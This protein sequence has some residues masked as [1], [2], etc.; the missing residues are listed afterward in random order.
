MLK[1]DL[2]NLAAVGLQGGSTP[3]GT[4]Q[5]WLDDVACTGTEDRLIECRNRG[6]GVHN[7]AHSEDAGVRCTG[8]NL[9]IVVVKFHTNILQALHA[10][11]E[12]SDCKEALPEGD[13]WR[14]ATTMP[15]AQCVTTSGAL[16]MLKW[17]VDSWDSVQ[18]VSS[19][20]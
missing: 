17:S 1:F 8:M 19:V 2:I 15:G 13:A 4:G 3:D 16:Q 5:I 20:V 14:S 11:G 7:C 6:L 10:L 12:L 18:L 9:H